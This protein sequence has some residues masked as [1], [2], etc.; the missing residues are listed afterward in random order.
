MIICSC[1]GLSDRDIE[2]VIHDGASK[3]AELYARKKCQ[4]KCGN[5][6]KNVKCL[7][8]EELQKKRTIINGAPIELYDNHAVKPASPCIVHDKER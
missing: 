3:L 6:L 5:C 8:K 7:F 4:V 2:T 1:N